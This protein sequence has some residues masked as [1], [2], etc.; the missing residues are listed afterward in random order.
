MIGVPL[1]QYK[2]PQMKR[3]MASLMHRHAPDGWRAFASVI[4]SDA[5]ILEIVRDTLTINVSEFYRQPDRYAELERVHI[6]GLMAERQN[7][8]IW[9]AGCSIGCEPY[10]LA[11]LLNELDSTGRHTIT[12]TDVDEIA[13]AQARR[14][15][16]Y[17]EDEVRSVPPAIRAKYFRKEGDTY[18]V[19]AL[20]RRF[21]RFRK[22]DLLKEPYP[23][24]LDMIVCRNVIIYFKEEAK[25]TIF[26]G[27]ARSLRPGGLLF[28]GGSEM[29]M[30]PG[31]L[32][33]K[34]ASTG[35]YRKVEELPSS[36]EKAG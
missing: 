24:D 32:G 18:T 19:D 12:A 34:T 3:R 14:G 31:E 23:R 2:E 8:K 36:L 17:P 5:R 33:L 6:P 35:M 7:L 16:D 29:I 20:L 30:R 10:S 26:D 22:H 28:I 13:L 9:S 25:K 4:R 27:F 15:N 11:I 21:I 1:W